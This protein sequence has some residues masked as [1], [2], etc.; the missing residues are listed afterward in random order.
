MLKRHGGV[1]AA[2][3]LVNGNISDGLRTLLRMGRLDMSVE[4]WVLFDRYQGLF[5]SSGLA[6]GDIVGT[7]RHDGR[8]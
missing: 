4:L 8:W 7:R 2:R 6:G 1:E 3:R 5:R